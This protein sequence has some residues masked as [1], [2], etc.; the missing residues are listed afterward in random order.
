MT[1]AFTVPPGRHLVFISH[2]SVDSWVAAQIAGHVQQC[3]AATFLDEAQIELGADFEADI[4]ANLERAN[5]LLVLLTPWGLSRPYV[6]A[7]LGAAWGR[8]IPIIGLLHG[9][10]LSDLQARPEIPIF[11][12]K[13]DMISLNRIDTYLDQLRDRLSAG[14]KQS[15][16]T[17]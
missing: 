1:P 13:R 17:S 10:E 15:D 6:W 12:K 14:E 7:E 9:I 4:L 5:E 8:R 3:G 2:S 11:L 16:E